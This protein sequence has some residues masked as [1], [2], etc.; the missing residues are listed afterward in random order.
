L[1]RR[2]ISILSAGVYSYQ[3]TSYFDIKITIPFQNG[4][5]QPAEARFF[6]DIFV[7]EIRKIK[8]HYANVLARRIVLAMA[9]T[10]STVTVKSSWFQRPTRIASTHHPGG[11]IASHHATGTDHSPIPNLHAR[12]YEGIGADPGIS[13]DAD[14][15]GIKTEA[16]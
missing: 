3:S 10:M 12:A 1:H 5:K 4:G 14:W 2:Q 16:G 11:L 9:I 7:E 8:R 13:A 6:D 15:F